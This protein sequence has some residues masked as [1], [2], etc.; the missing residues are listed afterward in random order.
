MMARP[1]RATIAPSIPLAPQEDEPVDLTQGPPEEDLGSP[2]AQALLQQS[3]VLQAIVHHFHANS[4]DPMAHLSSTTPTTGIKGTR[5]E[6]DL[7]GNLLQEW[8]I[9]SQGLP[10]DSEEKVPTTRPVSSLSETSSVSLL[11]YLERYGG[12][13]QNRSCGQ[14]VTF[15]TL[16]GETGLAA[17][18]LALTAAK[19]LWISRGQSA[20]GSSRPFA[21]LRAQTWNTVALAFMKEAEVLQGKRAELLSTRTPQGDPGPSP[22]L[23]PKRRPG[24]GKGANQAQQVEET[25]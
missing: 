11:A 14:L 18:H 2:M 23:S 24:R 22:K 25:G 3:K 7:K 16:A 4:A 19:N 21:P 13:G 8:T 5:Q 6:K 12:Y 10:I 20:T 1:A 15:S 17:D 9:L